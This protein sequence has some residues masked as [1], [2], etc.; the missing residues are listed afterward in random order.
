MIWR[1]TT[2]RVCRLLAEQIFVAWSQVYR[3]LNVLGNLGWCIN[4]PVLEVAEAAWGRGGDFAGLPSRNV[5][6]SVPP[7]AVP[8]RFRI[9]ANP[10]PF[11]QRQANQLTAQV[12]A[13]VTSIC[14]QVSVGGVCCEAHP[15]LQVVSDKAAGRRSCLCAT[16]AHSTCYCCCSGAQQHLQRSGLCGRSTT[17]KRSTELSRR[18]PSFL[19]HLVLLL[20]GT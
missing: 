14:L 10:Q 5:Q 18:A 11:R 1:G 16:C 12:R 8:Y 20:E 2:H 17:G 7:P 3:A 15:S 19:C 9:A 4:N 6:P 13:A